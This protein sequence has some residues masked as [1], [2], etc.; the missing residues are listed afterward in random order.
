MSTCLV[1]TVPPIS[2]GRISSPILRILSRVTRQIYRAPDQ[3][4]DHDQQAASIG[5]QP[6][7]PIEAQP[8]KRRQNMFPIVSLDFRARATAEQHQLQRACVCDVRC[9][10]KRPNGENSTCPAS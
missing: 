2:S 6:D 8:S 9:E 4:A 7:G 5:P 3:C 10:V 1:S